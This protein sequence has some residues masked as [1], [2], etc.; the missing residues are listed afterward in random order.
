M[1]LLT[2]ILIIASSV[3]NSLYN[4]DHKHVAT[5][6]LVETS[7]FAKDQINPGT[8]KLVV[9]PWSWTDDALILEELYDEAA[10]EMGTLLL[11][12]GRDHTSEII[13]SNKSSDMDFA[14]RGM[15]YT[16]ES[17]NDTFDNGDIDEDNADDIS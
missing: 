16:D 6:G 10:L 1:F 7:H 9:R 17:K 8:G 14:T 11:R 15:L 2:V 12:S 5:S 13:A 3:T 4:Q